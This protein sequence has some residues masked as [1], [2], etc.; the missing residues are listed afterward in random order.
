MKESFIYYNRKTGKLELYSGRE[1]LLKNTPIKCVGDE[2][3]CKALGLL[4][5]ISAQ[6]YKA[7][8]LSLKTMKRTSKKTK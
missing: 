7:L 1:E 4:T 2:S 6:Q 5:E 3:M 8:E